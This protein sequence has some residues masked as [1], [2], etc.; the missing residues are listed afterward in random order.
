M[1]SDH[2]AAKCADASLLAILLPV[3]DRVQDA[4]YMRFACAVM[5]QSLELLHE[6]SPAVVLGVLEPLVQTICL[7]LLTSD[8]TPA[9]VVDPVLRLLLYALGMPT[10]SSAPW[11]GHLEGTLLSSFAG[12]V[13]A[14][15]L[16]P[17]VEILFQRRL[18][19]S[20]FVRSIV[21]VCK[22][23]LCQADYAHF[24][25]AVFGCIVPQ[26]LSYDD[27]TSAALLTEHIFAAHDR[28]QLHDVLLTACSSTTCS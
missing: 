28:M 13:D 9:A 27:G 20:G 25:Q 11:L 5:E 3:A 2:L 8:A 21:D 14:A 17:V 6:V 16:G 10:S 26:I 23:I 19:S 12:T 22:T 4:N 18:V 15:W 7:P 1:A 24:R